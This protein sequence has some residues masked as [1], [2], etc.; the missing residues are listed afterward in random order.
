MLNSEVALNLLADL[1]ADVF[2]AHLPTSTPGSLYL[3][4]SG[5]AVILQDDGTWHAE[6]TTG[7]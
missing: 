2:C 7:G 3:Q 1:P 5:F 6:D 4:F